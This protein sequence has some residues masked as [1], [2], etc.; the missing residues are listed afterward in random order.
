MAAASAAPG[1]FSPSLTVDRAAGV[2]GCSVVPLAGVEVL[3]LSA[4][5]TEEFVET[6]RGKKN[7]P[8]NTQTGGAMNNIAQHEPELKFD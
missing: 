7:P 8:K 5:V 6:S 2:V 4:S 3:E 1:S